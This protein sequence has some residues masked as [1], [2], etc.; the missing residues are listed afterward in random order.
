MVQPARFRVGG[1]IYLNI[2]TRSTGRREIVYPIIS[3]V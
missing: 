2:P 1:L 3:V